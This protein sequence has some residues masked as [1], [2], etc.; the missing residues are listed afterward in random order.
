M[1]KELG[2]RHI[3]HLKAGYGGWVKAG[4]PVEK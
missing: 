4:N 2:F 3:M 1:F